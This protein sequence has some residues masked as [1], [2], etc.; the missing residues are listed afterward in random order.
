MDL[1]P[2][3]WI[4]FPG[5][6]TL[7]NTF[8]LFRREIELSAAPRRATGWI[9]A[10]SRY[11]LTVNGQ[12][13]QWGPAPCDPRWQDVDPID[14]TSHLVAGRNVVGI[15]VLYYSVGDGTWPMGSPGL[16]FKLDIDGDEKLAVVSD[17]SWKT[18]LDRA[19][20]PGMYK[21]WFLRALQEEFDARLHPFGWDTPQ[22]TPDERW[23]AARVL[24]GRADRSSLL[25][26]GPE[27][28]LGVARVGQE[29]VL[30]EREIP[31]LYETLVP[32]RRRVEV[33]GVTWKRDPLDWFESR[34]PDSFEVSPAED[35]PS[36]RLKPLSLPP[37][38]DPKQAYFAT[39]E[40]EEQV[41]G[42]P[43][44]VI[45][46]PQGTIVELMVQEA[47]DPSKTHWLDSQYFAWSRF[48]C[49]EGENHIEPFDFESLR[50]LQVHV[51]GATRPVTIKEVG[52]RRRVFPWPNPA[53]V[54]FD[55]P[56][57]QRLFDAAVNTL[58]NCAQETCVDGMA[59]ERQQYSGDGGHQLRAI[60]KTFGETRL[61]RRFL[62][63]FSE[64][65]HPDGYFM[66]C[67]P[68]FDRLA[69]LMQRFMG[70]SDWGPLLDHGVGF[71]FD[72]WLHYLDT[73]DLDALREPYPRLKRFADYLDR[74]VRPD[75]LLPVENLGI[76]AVWIDHDAYEQRRHAVCAFNLYTAAMLK[77]ALAPMAEAFDDL[78]FARAL[79]EN[80]RRLLAATVRAFWDSDHKLFVVNKPWLDQEPGPRFCDRSL[81]T[82]ILFDQL[83]I[84]TGE[85]VRMLAEFPKE[86]GLS[87]PANA[88][89]RYSALVK[90]GRADVVWDDFRKR[91]ATMQSVKLNNTIQESWEVEGDSDSQ[92]SHCAVVP[93]YVLFE[94]LIGLRP[95]TPGYRTYE[96]RPRLAEAPDFEA[97]AHT[98]VGPVRVKTTP[99]AD[100]CQVRVTAAPAGAGTLVADTSISLRPGEERSVYLHRRG[101]A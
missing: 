47:H 36:D 24:P 6:R 88:G 99:T 69:R 89:W 22:F 50:W 7:Q 55:D 33:G 75:G 48:I 93:L 12:R 54:K 58:N 85:A 23:L 21:R 10:D 3:R 8:I 84:D 42:W 77:H 51:R 67:W 46:A 59:R 61:P 20:R 72:C 39:Y 17:D 95:L 30:R 18:F 14:L 79:R 81:A 96:I 82:A 16:I 91:W 9:T 27:Y 94:D 49:R 2:A 56:D 80:G 92:W 25:A 52:V 62:R 44:V 63:T 29:F 40:W 41:V 97:T 101:R 60:R 73:G 74:L 65:Q 100:G 5:T 19:H 98:P 13:I 26:G 31:F 66:D 57:L 68:A 78:N 83:P 45:D 15:E 43:Y 87:Y 76:P 71:N 38:V 28:V 53:Q 11:R 86:L 35:G 1:S 70:T 32:A 64:G 90:G 4:W 37:S 34:V